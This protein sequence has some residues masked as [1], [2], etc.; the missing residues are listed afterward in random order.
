MRRGRARHGDASRD[1]LDEMSGLKCEMSGPT[2]HNDPFAR[3]VTKDE[4]DVRDG[5]A[6][7][8]LE[9]ETGRDERQAPAR[10]SPDDRDDDTR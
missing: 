4:I 2:Q 5:A 6:S 7:T 3:I 9:R 1:D 10:P 8:S